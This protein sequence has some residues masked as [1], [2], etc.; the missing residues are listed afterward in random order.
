MPREN[1]Y[2]QEVIQIFISLDFNLFLL[3]NSTAF[4]DWDIKN[5]TFY[6]ASSIGMIENL[7][8]NY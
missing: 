6:F 2:F 1:V 8:M 5:S 4:S 3:I 7:I